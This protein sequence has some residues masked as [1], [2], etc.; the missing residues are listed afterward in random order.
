MLG[1]LLV[2][3]DDVLL[4]MD[5]IRGKTSGKIVE[6]SR[7]YTKNHS[8]ISI[9]WFVYLLDL[10]F[11]GWYVVLYSSFTPSLSN[12][13]VQNLLKNLGSRLVISLLKRSQL[14]KS[15][16]LRKAYT[17]YLA[18]QVSTPSINIIRFKN[19]Y[20]IDINI[21]YPSLLAG[22]VRIKLRARVKKGIGGKSIGCRDL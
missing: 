15:S 10:S 6:S 4:R 13:A 14:I 8:T 20:I 22:R 7:A 3:E 21:L 17:H 5:C 18:V 12:N 19:L 2:V 11:W 9:F 1:V 16:L